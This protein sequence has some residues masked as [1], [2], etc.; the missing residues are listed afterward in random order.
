MRHKSVRTA[1]VQ[2]V[3]LIEVSQLSKSKLYVVAV[4]GSLEVRWAIV[5]VHKS[6]QYE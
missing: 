4:G 5:P 1:G 2:L 6:F 3:L